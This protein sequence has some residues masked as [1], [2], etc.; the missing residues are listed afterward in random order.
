MVF[1]ASFQLI[2]LNIY[3]VYIDNM[4]SQVCPSDLQLNKANTP[5]T[6]AIF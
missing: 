2:I 5:D 1:N 4:V 3:N 6:E